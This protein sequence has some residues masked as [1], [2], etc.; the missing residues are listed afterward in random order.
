[1]VGNNGNHGISICDGN[2][3]DIS[4]LEVCQVP[5]KTF[6]SSVNGKRGSSG[7]PAFNAKG[8]AIGVIYSGGQVSHNLIP[9]QYIIEDMKYILEDKI[10]P[11]YDLGAFFK[12]IKIKE[13]IEHYHL[14][15][16]LFPDL[17]IR[18]P[19]AP[20]RLLQVSTLLKGTPAKS[21][22]EVGDILYAINGKIVG[23]DLFIY[24]QELY[25]SEG[26]EINLD[27]YRN[28]QN[29]KL[30]LKPFDLNKT[31]AETIIEFGKTI[32]ISID[33]IRAYSTGYKIG[34]VATFG[35]TQG[36]VFPRIPSFTLNQG[37]LTTIATITE[38][39]GKP[40]HTLEDLITSIP[41]VIET[42]KF[43]YKHT[44]KGYKVLNNYMD[45]HKGPYS[46][47]G[48]YKK[49]LFAKPAK[50]VFDRQTLGW[51]RVDLV[52]STQK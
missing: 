27:I 19:G 41:L 34:A 13:A 9:I 43:H 2:L 1:M 46:K 20:N 5:L 33:P 50:I 30:T 45:T 37:R 52:E 23:P 7:S 14:P 8:E 49:T 17:N 24:H 18:F 42:P 25:N 40:I 51:K 22:L 39:Q 11:R 44:Y 4:G 35:N 21:C 29:I 12:H 32:F 16:N 26:K 3:S 10:P 38:L 47:S 6:N 48:E 28:G 36:T 31:K 15:G